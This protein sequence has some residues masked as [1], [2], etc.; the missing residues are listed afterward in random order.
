MIMVCEFC[1]FECEKSEIE[2]V[3]DPYCYGGKITVCT[4]CNEAE[5]FYTKTNVQ[6]QKTS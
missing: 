4:E 5:S 6:E 1:G 2:T 3:N